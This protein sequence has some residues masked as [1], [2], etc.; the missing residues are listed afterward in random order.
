MHSVGFRSVIILISESI[1]AM[2]F[3]PGT[4]DFRRSNSEYT[5]M[6]KAQNVMFASRV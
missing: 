2:N 1:I 6:L 5:K 4:G 3:P